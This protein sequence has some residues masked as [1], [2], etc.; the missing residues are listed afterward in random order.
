MASAT[1]VDDGSKSERITFLGTTALKRSLEKQAAA[2]GISVG[3]LIR[4]RFEGT[5]EEQEMAELT[6]QLRQAN[7]DARKALTSALNE[8]GSFIAE[9]AARRDEREG[10]SVSAGGKR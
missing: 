1:A 7:T 5:A 8:A 4:E 3:Q 2:R 6:K 9:M 10:L